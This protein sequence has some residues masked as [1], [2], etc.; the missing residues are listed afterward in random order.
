[1]AGKG[2]GGK[3]KR[4]GSSSGT[5]RKKRRNQ[6]FN[7][8]IY[9]VLKQVHPEIGIS[10]RGM[11][12]LNSF[13]RDTFGKIATEAGNLVKFGKK[14]TLSAREISTATKLILPGEL[15]KHANSEGSKAMTKYQSG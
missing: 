10:K 11:Q 15:A 14:Q 1:M 13:V 9:K 5:T 4:G 7:I 3:G 2:K 6:T 8:Y 12:I